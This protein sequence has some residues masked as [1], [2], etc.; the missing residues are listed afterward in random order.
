MFQLTE[1]LLGVLLH[2]LTLLTHTHTLNVPLLH[3]LYG[4]Y[5]AACTQPLLVS[6]QE[7]IVVFIGSN[8]SKGFNANIWLSSIAS[9]ENQYTCIL[10]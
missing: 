10:L 6:H 4:V 7:Y 8:M 1:K 9:A 2:V 3:M 5:K